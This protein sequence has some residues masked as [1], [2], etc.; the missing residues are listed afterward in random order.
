MVEVQKSHS[1]KKER[2]CEVLNVRLVFLRC[3][4]AA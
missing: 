4:C 1:R 2:G 3:G